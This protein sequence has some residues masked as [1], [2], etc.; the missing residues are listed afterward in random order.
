M[1]YNDNDIERLIGNVYKGKTT[2]E[3][4]PQK[5]YAQIA[6][7]LGEGVKIGFGTSDPNSIML[8][9]LIDNV[10]YFSAAKTFQQVKQMQEAIIGSN[11][12]RVPYTEFKKSA[13]GIFET[14]NR[15]W[16]KTEYNT[17]VGQSQNAELWENIMRDVELFPILTYVTTQDERVCPI[18]APLDR[19]TARASDSIWGKIMPSNHFGCLCTV[20]Q[21]EEGDVLLS[22]NKP[23]LDNIP[24]E[25]QFNPG[26]TQKVFPPS[27]PYFKVEKK[28]EKLK[29][30]NFNLP[31]Y[32]T[33]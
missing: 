14:Y 33:D 21:Q 13:L 10:H 8:E 29:E 30:N 16:L 2:V 1:I 28:Y 3:K 9:N 27:H 20:V 22:K 26:Q 11:G 5:L 23:S 15:D 7:H 17:A 4:P 31:A 6:Q 19:F 12:H 25:F 18:C 32:K 24:K